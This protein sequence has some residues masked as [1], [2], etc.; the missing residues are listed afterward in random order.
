MDTTRR[1]FVK[2]STAASLSMLNPLTVSLESK[3]LTKKSLKYGMIQEGNTVLEKFNL[4][5]ELGFDGVEL[6]SPN[7]L[8]NREILIARDKTGILID[9]VVNSVHWSSPLSDAD[10]MVRAK[11]VESMKISLNDCKLYGGSSVLLVPA[12]VNEKVSYQEAYTRSQ[13]EIKKI[14]PVAE[15]TGIKIAIENVWNNFLLS[16][17]EAARYIDEFKNP[18]IGWHFDIGN[19]IRYGYPEQ[20][21]KV[22]GKRII[23]T[24]I[25]DYSRK[26]ANDEGV[27]KGFNAELGE[28]DVDWNAVN[29]ALRFIGY[30]GWG[31]AEVPGGDR[32]RLE[33]ISKRMDNCYSR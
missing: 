27:W 25:K 10:P 1:E 4:I 9:G 15:K 6:D 20:W 29:N 13:A 23:K 22:L 5:K 18:M 16:P 24:D 7:Q 3:G 12:V 11:C 21:I 17:I 31:A 28:G 19:I 26:K 30:E 33:E 14:L 8:D 32:K 2:I